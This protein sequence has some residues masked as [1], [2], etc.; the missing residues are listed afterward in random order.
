M[1]A[2]GHTNST[3][4][5]RTDLTACPA[6]GSGRLVSVLGTDMGGCL[7]CMKFW[8][9]LPAGEPYLVD[10]EPMPFRLPC[11]NCAF[12]GKSPERLDPDT[13]MSLMLSLAN[14]GEFYCHKATPFV[15]LAGQTVVKN[16]EHPKKRVTVDL[17][18]ECVETEVYDRERMRLCRGF[19]NAFVPRSRPGG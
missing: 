3:S 7:S 18:G 4:G 15:Y 9:R 1:S 12:R 14:G 5:V 2:T 13:W 16:W 11:D 6:C 10:G 17:A 19:L 8:E